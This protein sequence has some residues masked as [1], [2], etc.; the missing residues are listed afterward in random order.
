MEQRSHPNR[1]LLRFLTYR[2]KRNTTILNDLLLDGL[3]WFEM[4][5]DGLE[6]NN[7]Q[8]I[9]GFF[10]AS[11]SVFLPLNLSQCTYYLAS[12]PPLGSLP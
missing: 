12:H 3:G 4:T 11:L 7:R 9:H 6:C 10:K 5:W 1:A 8:G 2:T